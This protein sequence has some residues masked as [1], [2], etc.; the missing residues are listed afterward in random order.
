MEKAIDKDLA[1]KSVTAMPRSRNFYNFFINGTPEKRSMKP[2]RFID[3]I[4][5]ICPVVGGTARRMVYEFRPF[6]IEVETDTILELED[7]PGRPETHKELLFG[8]RKKIIRA[9]KESKEVKF[10]DDRKD[11]IFRNILKLA[12]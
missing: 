5:G 3:F 8:S 12:R 9:E 10:V 2:E 7:V 11:R 1:I 4:I 6:Y